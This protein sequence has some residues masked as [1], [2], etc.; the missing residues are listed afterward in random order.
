[1]ART[2][3]KC[4]RSGKGAFSGRR[5]IVGG[6]RPAPGVARSGR[7]TLGSC[8]RKAHRRHASCVGASIETTQRQGGAMS[9]LMTGV[10]MTAVVLA[11]TFAMHG[12]A[13]AEKFCPSGPC[14][15]PDPIP[16]PPPQSVSRPDVV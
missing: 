11:A 4:P 2:Y 6:L 9:K 8:H 12:P 15:P 7:D 10:F 5:A 3:R 13:E 1:M 16:T 14:E